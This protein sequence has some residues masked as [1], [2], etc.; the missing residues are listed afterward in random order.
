MLRLLRDVLGAE[1]QPGP[2]GAREAVRFLLRTARRH[3]VVFWISD[4]E[5]PLDAA[6]LAGAG[7]PPRRDRA[8]AARPARR[9]RCRPW[10]GWRSRTSRRGSGGSWTAATGGRASATGARRRGA[11]GPPAPRSPQARCPLLVLQTGRPWLP[12]LMR[13][14][15]ERRRGRRGVRRARAVAAAAS[16]GAGPAPGGCSAPRPPPAAGRAAPR[17]RPSRRLPLPGLASGPGSRGSGSRC[18]YRGRVRGARAGPRSRWERAGRRAARSSGAARGP[19]RT[20]R[21]SAAPASGDGGLCR[22]HAAGR[23]LRCRCSRPGCVTRPR[24]G[25]RGAGPARGAAGRAACRWS[26]AG[27]RPGGEPGGHQRALRPLRGPLG[28]PWWERVP[29]RIVGLVALALV[30]AGLR[31]LAPDAPPGSGRASPCAPGR[32]KDPRRRGA[33]GA[34]GAARPAPAGAGP[35]RRAC[36]R[37]HA[38]PEALPRGHR[39][40][41]RAPATARRSW[42]STCEADAARRRP[43]ASALAALLAAWD[44]VK[45]ARAASSPEEARRAEDAVEE[46]ARRRLAGRGRGGRLMRWEAPWLPAPAAAPAAA[47]R[48]CVAGGRPTR[49]AAVLWAQRGRRG[50]G[51]RAGSCARSRCCRGWRWRS[52]SSPSRGRSRACA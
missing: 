51:A 7:A 34:R 25:L 37:A 39:R 8:A 15:A 10:A 52:R 9:S 40:A 46:L 35:L 13:Y 26:R 36:V 30:V 31:R 48:R 23:G 29:W 12:L 17:P 24:P 16:P 28:A 38:H 42:W 49:P 21:A 18:V 41:R 3:S 33:R 44:R 1:A 2:A 20:P 43:S 32:A 27:G 19:R 47:G 50:R 14:F 22:G 5:D 6:R 4:F 11:C 45:F